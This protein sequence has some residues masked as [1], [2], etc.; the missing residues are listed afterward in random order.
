LEWTTKSG[1]DSGCEPGGPG[2][3]GVRFATVTCQ[4]FGAL[5]PSSSSSSAVAELVM[6]AAAASPASRTSK[7]RLI[8]FSFLGRTELTL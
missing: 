4:V 6:S 2:P 1:G 8:P 3:G 7:V 5:P